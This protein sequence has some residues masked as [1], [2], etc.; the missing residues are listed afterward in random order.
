VSQRGAESRCRL[1]GLTSAISSINAG[2]RCC[3]AG[4]TGARFK[5]MQAIAVHA[6]PIG[7]GGP[8]GTWRCGACAAP[9]RAAPS[10]SSQALEHCA[11]CGKHNAGHEAG[12]M[13]A[14]VRAVAAGLEHGATL[15]QFTAE[16]TGVA[17]LEA[18]VEKK[19]AELAEAVRKADEV[20]MRIAELE[21]K[22]PHA[23]LF[24]VLAFPGIALVSWIG[25]HI[26]VAL[27]NP[28]RRIRLRSG[29]PRVHGPSRRQAC[30]REASCKRAGSCA[31]PEVVGDRSERAGGVWC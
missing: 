2:K 27:Q 28:A 9:L 8:F 24:F 30:R 26:D 20:A 15:A 10:T 29:R 7:K 4:A 3:G 23:R 12:S 13:L 16:L 19:R 22:D 5:A 18:E 31:E 14:M 21:R 1:R 25:Y 11:A 6:F 17:K